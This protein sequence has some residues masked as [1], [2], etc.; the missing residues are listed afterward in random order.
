MSKWIYPQAHKYHILLTF[1]HW[2][3]DL[4]YRSTISFIITF[5]GSIWSRTK[6]FWVRASSVVFS[7]LQWACVSSY[8]ERGQHVAVI[9][10]THLGRWMSIFIFRFCYRN[11]GLRWK[12]VT[13][14]ILSSALPV[15]G[16]LVLFSL[17]SSDKTYCYSINL[18]DLYIVKMLILNR[19]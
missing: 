10:T 9:F 12:W 13:G 2:Q 7:A 1:M 14:D 15:R 3:Y 11:W 16:Y 6:I 18:N 8:E 17:L 19:L 5:Y 4:K